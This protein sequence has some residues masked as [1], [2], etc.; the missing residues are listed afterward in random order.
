MATKQVSLRVGQQTLDNLR[1]L[2][3]LMRQSDAQ[4]VTEWINTLADTIRI[5]AD[6]ANPA[7]V[8]DP[9]YLKNGGTILSLE[10]QQAVQT[11][12]RCLRDLRIPGA[13]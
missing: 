3:I 10:E 11:I 2:G 13:Q 12:Q 8:A 9:Q 1:Y 4:I 5:M 7:L 6:Q